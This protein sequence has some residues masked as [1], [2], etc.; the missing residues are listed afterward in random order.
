MIDDYERN[1][2]VSGR[3]YLG[4]H[5]RMSHLRPPLFFVH[6]TTCFYFRRGQYC[7]VWPCGTI[8]IYTPSQQDGIH[9]TEL[10]ARALYSLLSPFDF[11]EGRKNKS[12]F[13]AL[14]LRVDSL[15]SCAGH[16]FDDPPRSSWNH[17]RLLGSYKRL[18]QSRKT[19]QKRKQ[20]GVII[21]PP[22][23]AEMVNQS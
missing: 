14:L 7:Q 8:T 12:L 18:G 6:D 21:S 10:M 1:R 16:H 15:P 2:K 4:S 17:D 9:C 5:K 20:G 3:G 23:L 22:I 19:S 13:S 11:Q